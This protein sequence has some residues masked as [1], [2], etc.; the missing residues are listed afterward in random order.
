MNAELQHLA[1]SLAAVR[2]LRAG[3][4][5][6][7]KPGADLSS[8]LDHLI[9]AED[10]IGQARHHLGIVSEFLTPKNGHES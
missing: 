6:A 1:A 8:L 2:E 5:R 3:L 9:S 10:G 7:T 4:E